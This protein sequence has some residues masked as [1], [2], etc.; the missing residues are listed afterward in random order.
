MNTLLILG[1]YGNAGLTIARLLAHQEHLKIILA[2]RNGE[3]AKIAAEQLNAEFKTDGFSSLQVN[4]ASRGSLLQVF[5]GI[6]LVVVAAS[7]I[8]YTETVAH[9]ALEARIDYFDL[10]ISVDAKRKAL[11][12]LRERIVDAG[13]CFI[14]DGGYRPGI[15][16]AMVRYAASRIER[17]E[18][19][20][21]SSVFQ[22]NWKDREF[23]A[24]TAAEFADEIESFST[25]VLKDGSWQRASMSEFVQVDFGTPFGM[26]YCMPMFMEELRALPEL[27]PTLKETGFYSSGFGGMVDYVIIPL[28]MGLL[29]VARRRSRNLIA[30]LVEWG[31][32]NTTRPP[33]GAVLQ[34]Q[35]QGQGNALTMTVAHPDSYTLTAVPVVACLLQYLD[36]TIRQPGLWRQ[37]TVVEPVRFFDDLAKMGVQ[38]NFN[39]GEQK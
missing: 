26:K 13:C 34:M 12:S 30:R 25:L 1:G 33:Y 28:A 22:V 35:A 17:L 31:L 14:T 32:K 4:A 3:R 39:E 15:P 16:A 9:A 6:D 38:I 29:A 10:Q 21:V 5:Q 7:T 23:A 11:E 8:Q 24:S 20:R 19:A 37:A 2:G 36:G 27:I 18:S